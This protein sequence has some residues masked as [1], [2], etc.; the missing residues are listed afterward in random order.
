M[1]LANDVSTFFF[2]GKTTLTTKDQELYLEIFF[3][4]L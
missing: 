4:D 2:D 3:F 1:F